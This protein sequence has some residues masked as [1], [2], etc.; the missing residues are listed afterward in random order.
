MKRK[1]LSSHREF[2]S[3]LVRG[4]AGWPLRYKLSWFFNSMQKE[5]NGKKRSEFVRSRKTDFRNRVWN[6]RSTDIK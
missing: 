1:L 3:I 4:E 2:S 5:K 6:R